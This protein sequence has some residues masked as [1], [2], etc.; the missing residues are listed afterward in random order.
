MP[1]D[2]NE[3]DEKHER[4]QQ[5]AALAASEPDPKKMLALVKEVI[6]LLEQHKNTIQNPA[7]SPR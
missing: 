6:A 7:G 4:L 3:K 1:D 5:L 2:K